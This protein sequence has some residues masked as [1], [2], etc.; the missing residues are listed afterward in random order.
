M[1]GR[2][3]GVEVFRR[4]ALDERCVRLYLE[5]RPASPARSPCK[6]L[7]RRDETAVACLPLVPPAQLPGECRRHVDLIHRR[8]APHPRVSLGER[9]GVFGEQR[10]PVG[11]VEPA[12]PVRHAEMAQVGDR[13]DLHLLQ[14]AERL[15]AK[16]SSRISR[17]Q[18]RLVVRRAVPQVLHAQSFTSPKSSRHRL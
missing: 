2:L 10:R 1:H 5:D 14:R 18:V 13:L 17:A 8:V 3:V 15:V 4:L 7:E 6:V 16:R 9:P 12:H 11:V